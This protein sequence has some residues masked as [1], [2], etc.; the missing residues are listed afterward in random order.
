MPETEQAGADKAGEE[1]NLAAMAASEVAK[2]SEEAK[3]AEDTA[4]EKPAEQSERAAKG[5]GSTAHAKS[6]KTKPASSRTSG[7]E[8]KVVER[9]VVTPQ[10][11]SHDLEIKQGSGKYLR[12]I[13]NIAF[14]LSKI[15]GKDDFMGALHKVLYRRPGK[16]TTRK[17]DILSFS[18]F[19]YEDPEE[20]KE[21]DVERVLKLK[22]DEIHRIMD[23]LDI[24]RG[25]GGKEDKAEKVIEFLQSPDVMRETN[26]A[27][28]ED[29]KKAAAKRKREKL[30]AKKAK[31]AKPAAKG[32]KATKK[33]VEESEEEEEEEQ[34]EEEEVEEEEEEKAPPP[35]KAKAT[36]KAAAKP[37]KAA[38]PKKAAAPPK[39]A[40]ASSKKV[41]TPAKSKAEPA[42]PAAAFDWEKDDAT[43]SEEQNKLRRAAIDVMKTVDLKEFSLKN[44]LTSLSEKFGMDMAE[45]KQM[46]KTVAVAYCH[47]QTA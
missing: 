24:P 44:L 46:L 32:K 3:P 5:E 27:E 13:P 15:S 4:A 2:H 21:K 30:V 40:A 28:K 1:E 29:A 10:P 11:V 19:V 38:P 37:K 9:F 35:K 26:L 18:G 36:A 41:V 22:N 45:H 25:S 17:R 6:P 8:R 12:D 23:T 43:L 31:K 34:E 16:G 33:V 14:N 20:G 42:S 39:K 47:D 7:R